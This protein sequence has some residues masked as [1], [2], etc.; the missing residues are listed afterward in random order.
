MEMNTR[1]QVEHPVT[2]MVTGID[3]VEQ[4]LRVAAGEHL[5]DDVTSVRA[6]G[7]QRR[8][9]YLRREPGARIFADEW[10]SPRGREPSVRACAWT[11]RCSRASTSQR[12][13]TRCWRRWWRGDPIEPPRLLGCLEALEETVIFGVVTNVGFFGGSLQSRRRGRRPRHRTDRTR[14]RHSSVDRHRTPRSHSSPCRG[15]HDLTPMGSTARS[16]GGAR[17]WRSGGRKRPL[18]CA[19]S[20]ADTSGSSRS[21]EPS[22]TANVTVA[23]GAMSPRD[24]P[25]ETATHSSRWTARPNA[26]GSA[27]TVAT[28]WVCVGGETWPLRR[29]WT[30]RAAFAKR[31]VV[32]Q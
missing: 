9:A 11:A 31:R 25:N 27:S 1:L 10:T 29:R 20:G 2:E 15:C 22:T 30:S 12:T 17:G 13:T 14:R 19:C 28:T 16:L 32:L 6:P 4:Q 23:G 7:P 24:C 26:P 5:S 3:L 18:T 21:R 8:G